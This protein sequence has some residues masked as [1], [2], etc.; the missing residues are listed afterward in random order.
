MNEKLIDKG[1]KTIELIRQGK[2]KNDI[3]S[4]LL[5]EIDNTIKQYESFISD[6]EADN[7]QK[8]ITIQYDIIRPSKLKLDS[9]SATRLNMFAYYFTLA[10]EFKL[11]LQLNDAFMKMNK[12]QYF[13]QWIKD[14]INVK[15]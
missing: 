4:E 6:L 14:K 10:T 7:L 12:E 5:I 1:N 13:K 3:V 2:I 15:H 8:D 9:I 11:K